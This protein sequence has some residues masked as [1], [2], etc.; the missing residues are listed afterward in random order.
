M[1]NRIKTIAV[2]GAGTMGIGIAQVAAMAGYK[3]QLFDTKPGL[4]PKAL[5]KIK[6]NL[7]KGVEKGKIEVEQMTATLDNISTMLSFRDI[8][9]DMVIEAVIEDLDIKVT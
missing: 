1:G 2:I 7:K 8:N 4:V 6:N 5:T 9:A 3:V